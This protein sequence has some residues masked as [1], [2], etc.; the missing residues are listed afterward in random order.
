V[1][2]QDSQIP[3]K[4]P[5]DL[6]IEFFTRLNT[7]SIR[8]CHWKS[9]CRLS[10][11]LAGNTDLDLLFDRTQSRQL[12]QLLARLDFKPFISP[13]HRQFPTV[14]DYLGLD[15]DSGRLAH[16]HVYYR[17]VLG[18]QFVKNYSLPVADCFLSNTRLVDGVR[19]PIPELELIVF[20]LL[21]LLK[22]R[23]R[24]LLR[25]LLKQGPTGLPPRA[26]AELGYLQGQTDEN[27]IARVLNYFPFLSPDLVFAFLDQVRSNP[28]AGATLYALRKRTR[29][30][31]A[32]YQR[33][34]RLQARAKY[35][36]VLFARSPL[37][38]SALR[39][40]ST[41]KK[42]IPGTGGLSIAFIGSD[43]TGKSTVT[44]AMVKWLSWRVEARVFYMG[45]T[46]PS[47]VNRLVRNVRRVSVR[48]EGLFAGSIFARCSRFCECLRYIA[49]GFDRYRQYEKGRKWAAGGGIALFDRYP[50]PQVKVTGRP[51][52]GPRIGCLNT[53]K[54]GRI[55]RVLARIEESL[56][57]RI[58]APENLVV[59]TATP[60][61][62]IARKPG[63]RISTIKAKSEAVGSIETDG[64]RVIRIDAEKPAEETLLN[65][66]TAL[67][68]LL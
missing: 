41:G 31:L 36:R 26:L 28:R 24:D 59:L 47:P 19:I 5:L 52:D 8:Y 1:K 65:V 68:E 29:K 22:Y 48:L 62:C 63:H 15:R 16:L 54:A 12:H 39:G 43:G 66:K 11:G 57:R 67:W 27:E 46:S 53:G 34:S 7:E 35:Y 17:L 51:M 21:C 45:N 40:V 50:L 2:L 9:T 20:V 42:K 30:D 55:Q 14:E 49:D 10:K 44:R 56:Y 23:D 6:L 37:L 33:Y 4:R 13:P 60:E 18:E 38:S 64:M 61:V 32:P 3:G 58:E 25:D